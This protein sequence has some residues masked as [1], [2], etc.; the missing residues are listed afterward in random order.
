M[1]DFTIKN[2]TPRNNA[3][4]KAYDLVQ[5]QFGSLP[6]NCVSLDKEL[7]TLQQ[8]IIDAYKTPLSSDEELQKAYKEQLEAKKASWEN[9]FADHKCRDVIEK[10]RL[11]SIANTETTSAIK[12]EE[13]VL[14]K[15][16]K[17]ENTYIGIGA[18]IL[19]VGL[20]VVLKK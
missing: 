9:I 1:V 3:L 6:L 4:A 11:A 12:Q 16:T 19:L 7:K 20:F 14:G 10:I 2:N 13:S 17:N 15:S 8:A 5:S 18:V